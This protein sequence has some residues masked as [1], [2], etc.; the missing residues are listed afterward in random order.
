[1]FSNVTIIYSFLKDKQF[2]NDND[3]KNSIQKFINF[4]KFKFWR[5]SIQNARITRKT[6][7]NS[8]GEYFI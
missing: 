3:I 4:N 8:N 6:Q 5:N 1:M 7:I 2:T